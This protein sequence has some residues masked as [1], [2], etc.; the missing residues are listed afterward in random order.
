MPAN[1][2][3]RAIEAHRATSMQVR[4]DAPTNATDHTDRTVVSMTF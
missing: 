2:V 1:H 4:R 3:S